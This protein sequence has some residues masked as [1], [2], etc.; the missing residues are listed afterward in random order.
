MWGRSW[1]GPPEEGMKRHQAWGAGWGMA[2]LHVCSRCACL[3]TAVLL[4][5]SPAHAE[6]GVGWRQLLG[7]STRSL[8]KAGGVSCCCWA[9]GNYFQ[10]W[11]GGVVEWETLAREEEE[12]WLLRRCGSAEQAPPSDRA[13]GGA[14]NPCPC[15][16]SCCGGPVRCQ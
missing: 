2:V 4:M 10:L 7:L 9:G 8:V 14:S 1:L 15:T 11:R 6:P 3:R 16:G 5:P 12:G 13:G